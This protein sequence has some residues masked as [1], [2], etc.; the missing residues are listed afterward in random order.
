VR[1]TPF[2]RV[3]AVVGSNQWKSRRASQSVAGESKQEPARA[4]RSAHPA[5][6]WRPPRPITAWSGP[7]GTNKEPEHPQAPPSTASMVIRKHHPSPFRCAALFL[8]WLC[9]YAA[10][11]GCANT[12]NSA[13]LIFLPLNYTAARNVRWKWESLDI[14]PVIKAKRALIWRPS[15]AGRP[16]STHPALTIFL[17]SA[18]GPNSST[19]C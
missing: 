16:I 10:W 3:S 13:T 18:Q 8:S 11:S 15:Q 19:L 7:K 9:H 14:L 12:P 17:L 1:A 6:E 5:A 2:Q 4:S